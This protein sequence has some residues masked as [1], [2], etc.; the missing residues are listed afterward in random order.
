MLW[1]FGKPRARLR[2]I[3]S[4]HCGATEAGK[5]P[6]DP[7]AQPSRPAAPLTASLSATSPPGPA[8]PPVG[9]QQMMVMSWETTMMLDEMLFQLHISM[10]LCPSRRDAPR[11]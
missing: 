1:G 2:L 6:P 4:Q 10:I 11:R 5:A 8:L 3:H 7:Q 9:P